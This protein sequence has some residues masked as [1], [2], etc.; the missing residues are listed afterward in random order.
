MLLCCFVIHRENNDVQK[1]D[2]RRWIKLKT[3]KKKNVET[4][5]DLN[6]I[7]LLFATCAYLLREYVVTFLG[8][9]QTVADCKIDDNYETRV[10]PI[11]IFVTL[12]PA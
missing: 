7:T 3:E 8:I 4:H 1:Y 2:T 9:F 6:E 11:C 5:E 10:Y 12:R